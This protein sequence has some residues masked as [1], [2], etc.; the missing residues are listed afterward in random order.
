MHIYIFTKCPLSASSRQG[1]L[2]E[3]PQSVFA[4]SCNTYV[5]SGYHNL[6]FIEEES[7]VQ[8]GTFTG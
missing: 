8:G 3:S 7:E 1:T 2:S 5:G 6:L 4:A